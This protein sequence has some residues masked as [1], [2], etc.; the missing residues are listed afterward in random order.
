MDLNKLFWVI[1]VFL[2]FFHLLPFPVFC[3]H[4]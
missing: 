3:A 1:C 2:L 4:S